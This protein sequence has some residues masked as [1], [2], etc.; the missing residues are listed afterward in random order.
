MSDER[1]TTLKGPVRKA[2]FALALAPLLGGCVAAALAVPALTATGVLTRRTYVRAATAPDAGASQSPTVRIEPYGAENATLT[3]LTE[4]PLP[5]GAITRLTPWRTFVDHALAR[6]DTSGKGDGK[7]T[8]SVLL[9]PRSDIA[10]SPRRVPCRGARPAVLIDL[11]SGSEP[12]APASGIAPLPGLAGELA[13]LREAGVVVLWISQLPAGRVND[14]ASAL[15]TSGLDPAGKD[16]LLLVRH[17]EDRKQI[18]R[19]QA[20]EDVCIVAIAGDGRSDF[21][22]LF[23]Y[24]RDPDAALGL[25]TMIGGGWF[26]APPAFVPA[27]PAQPNQ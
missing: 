4:L 18:L 13:R 2:W 16:P 22:E 1:R 8:E 7:A 27:T 12:F 14:V 15:Q 23:D 9:V 26:L 3:Q 5:A 21:D 25:Q 19:E 17:A 10:I 6:S 11:D 20:N 24:L